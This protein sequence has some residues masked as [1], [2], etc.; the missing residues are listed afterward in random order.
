MG[1]EVD[2][3]FKK[4]TDIFQHLAMLTQ[5]GLS[6]ITPLLTCVGICAYLTSRFNF[7]GW[8]FIPGFFFGLGGSSMV[9]YKFYLSCN[10]KEKKDKKEN[11]DRRIGFNRHV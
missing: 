8:I 9:L 11:K 4:Y 2:R 6:F 3:M 7:G 5:L 1:Q 10:E